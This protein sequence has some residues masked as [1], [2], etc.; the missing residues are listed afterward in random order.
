MR[1]RR[2]RAR[3]L[4][5]GV[6]IILISDPP[7]EPLCVSLATLHAN[8]TGWRQNDFIVRAYRI[9]SHSR[10]MGIADAGFSD[11][12]MFWFSGFLALMFWVFYHVQE[13]TFSHTFSQ[14]S[15]VQT[16]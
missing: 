3:A 11:V 9:R 14:L 2:R 8:Y 1:G 10:A 13:P 4:A 16:D 7:P 6:K 5:L 15:H 12:L